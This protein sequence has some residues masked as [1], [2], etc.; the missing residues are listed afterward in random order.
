MRQTFSF[1]STN[2]SH[3]ISRIEF[4]DHLLSCNFI[5][6]GKASPFQLRKR[7][8]FCLSAQHDDQCQASVQRS[9]RVGI[10]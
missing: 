5:S 8:E 7:I 6:E 10:A 4:N 3:L 2:R 9:L 1:A